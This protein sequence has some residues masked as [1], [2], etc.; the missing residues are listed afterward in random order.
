MVIWQYKIG[1][2]FFC[3]VLGFLFVLFLMEGKRQQEHMCADEDEFII[4]VTMALIVYKH[5]ASN[6]F[7]SLF[8]PPLPVKAKNSFRTGLS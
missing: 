7:V 5:V 2:F 3:F 6:L 1:E 8:V 4:P